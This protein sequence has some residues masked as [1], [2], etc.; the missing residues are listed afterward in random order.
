MVSFNKNNAMS[1]AAG[2]AG[3]GAAFGPYGAV[4]GGVAG[5]VL[6]GFMGGDNGE[7][8]YREQ[9]RLIEESLRDIENI[10]L[11]ELERIAYENPEWLENLVASKQQDSQL[12]N[13]STDPRLK[14]QQ[15]AAMSALDEIV[16]GGGMTA[17]DEANLSMIQNQAATADRGRREAIMQ[18]M[19]QRGMGGSGMELLN[20]LQSSQA[21][22]NRQAQGGL[23]VA[24]MAQQRALDSMLN[25][26]QMAGQMRAQ[27]F[28]EQ[29]RI[30]QAQDVI[31]QFNTTNQ[32]RANEFNTAGRQDTANMGV[33]TRNQ[34]TQYNSQI[35]QQDYT[36]QMNKAGMKASARGAQVDMIGNKR[37]E[38]LQTQANQMGSM[39]QM[40]SA[41]G[42][43]Y[44]KKNR[45]NT[46]GGS[47]D[48]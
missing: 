13:I 9:E 39:V 29:S 21:A 40:G 8:A 30:A 14:N 25:Q 47:N 16:Q 44:D 17:A 22:T 26:G 24:A 6:G 48:A 38:D 41:I 46:Q 34:A 27:D 19:D 4:I 7:A 3:A 42:N 32:M 45:N 10:P 18:N 43:Y 2:G 33:N 37:A 11:P 15:M 31:N 36:N 12:Q 1:G 20:Q 35:P 23:D 5:G 28:G